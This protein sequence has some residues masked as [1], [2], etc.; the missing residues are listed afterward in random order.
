M[1]D[2]NFEVDDTIIF[3]PDMAYISL[4]QCFGCDMRLPADK[5]GRR[6]SFGIPGYGQHPKSRHAQCSNLD[7]M[8]NFYCS[9][10]FNENIPIQTSTL[11]K[12]DLEKFNQIL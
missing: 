1:R 4:P 10:F 7:V 3:T 6:V 9:N 8:V 11:I 12:R 5:Y 2:L